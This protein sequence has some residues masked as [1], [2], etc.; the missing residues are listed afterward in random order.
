MVISILGKALAAHWQAMQ[1][2]ASTES[3]ESTCESSI[4]SSESNPI[5]V[6]LRRVRGCSK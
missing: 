5:D 1:R 4:E 3:S 6:D 2:L